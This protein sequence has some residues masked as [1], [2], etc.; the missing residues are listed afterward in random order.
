MYDFKTMDPR[1]VIF[2]TTF[3]LANRLQMVMDQDL[4]E[5]TCKQWF[6]M[7]SL[8]LFDEAP[9]LKELAK[10]CDSSHQNTKQ[11]V[12]KLAEK[13]FVRIE[14]DSEDGRALRI[15]LA[16]AGEAWILKNQEKSTKF[17]DTMF[18]HLSQEELLLMRDMQQTLYKTL[19]EMEGSK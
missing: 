9:T 8:G 13:N 6:V 1:Y 11:I 17:I 16:E 19:G 2:A 14:K 4:E 10:A 12:L 15:Y 7:T 18:K 3:T 5:I